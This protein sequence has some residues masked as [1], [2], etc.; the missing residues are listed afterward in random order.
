MRFRL[1]L[2]YLRQAGRNL[3]AA[4]RTAVLGP[5]P[6]Q[7]LAQV[8]VSE[9]T[10]PSQLCTC[11]GGPHLERIEHRRDCAWA[12]LM[13]RGRDGDGLCRRCGGDGVRAQPA[14]DYQ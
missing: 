9:V 6:L 14:G 8:R 13:C 10:H 12:A 2:R 5:R 7:P 4:A 11:P 3:R 1:C